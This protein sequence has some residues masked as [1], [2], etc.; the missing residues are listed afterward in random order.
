M[1][2]L[3][4]FAITSNPGEPIFK[5]TLSQ[6]V[7]QEV[8]DYLKDQEAAFRVAGASE[9]EFDGKYKPEEGEVLVINNFKPEFDFAS[10]IDNANSIKEIP[11]N[12]GAFGQIKG[13][14]SGYKD[15]NGSYTVLIQHFDKR[16]VLSTRGIS[17]Y[18]SGSVYKKVDGIGLTIDS[19]LSAVIKGS[20]LKFFS[21]HLLRQVFD[22]SAHYREATDKDIIEFSATTLLKVDDVNAVIAASDS[23]V[24][25]KVSLVQ[26]SK[27]LETTPIEILKAVAAELDVDLV[28]DVVDGAEVIILPTTKAELKNILNFLAEDYYISPLS[29]VPHITNSR[30]V[31]PKKG[32]AS[33]SS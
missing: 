9:I 29:K 6:G 1:T 19:S 30:R 10:C 4:L 12:A 27:I 31:K 28:T 26:Q 11:S 18:H 21:F 16:K 23:I 20:T 13:I 2:M 5:F 14:F 7:Q 22:L 17:L 24:R 25:R 8:S 32:A 33:S 15:A 3:E